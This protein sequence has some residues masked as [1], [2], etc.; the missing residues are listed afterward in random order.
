MLIVDN[1]TR[2]SALSVVKNMRDRK[3]NHY[4]HNVAE[5]TEKTLPFQD[6][7]IA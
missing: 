6:N 3:I 1:I 5:D 2:N 7:S 4:H